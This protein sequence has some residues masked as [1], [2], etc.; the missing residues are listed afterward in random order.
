M[1]DPEAPGPRTVDEKRFDLVDDARGLT[2]PAAIWR[3]AD[4]ASAG[5]LVIY[6][7]PSGASAHAATFLTTHL[8]GHGYVV[9]A[10]DHSEVVDPAL[11]A[12]D[13]ETPDDR[14]KRAL[15]WVDNRLPDVR[16]LLEALA[17]E[18][19]RRVGVVGHSFGGWTALAAGAQDP[20]VAAVVALAPAGGQPARPGIIPVP[21]PF[22]DSINHPPTLV[23][24]ADRD[25]A[26]PLPTV[27]QLVARSPGPAKLVVLR[28][29]DHLHFVDDVATAHE[30][31]RALPAE[32]DLDW[33]SE[34]LPVESLMPPEQAHALVR[35]HTLAHFDATLR[36][37]DE[38][39]R[40]LASAATE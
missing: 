37:D 12:T 40:W 9:A 20:R 11:Q 34:M 18:H 33:V 36:G 16:L 8:A 4:A 28:E 27:Q 24:A 3:P 25:V 15:R 14:H 22:R 6:S 35:S 1:Y 5:P 17:E 31:F 23:I 13:G 7:H 30:E 2:F 26:V 29:A 32:G 39:R 21:D 38:A 19:P 10:M